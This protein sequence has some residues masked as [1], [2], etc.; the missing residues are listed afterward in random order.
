MKIILI[1]P[2]AIIELLALAIGWV[3]AFIHRP[4]GVRWVNWCIRSLPDRDWYS[5]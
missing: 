3:L 2:M 1:I 4:T 5:S